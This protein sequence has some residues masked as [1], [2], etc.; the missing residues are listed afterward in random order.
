M[1]EQRRKWHAVQY[2]NGWRATSGALVDGRLWA[3]YPLCQAYIDGIE[4][5]WR[6]ATGESAQGPL[7]AMF[8][9]QGET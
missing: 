2:E 1:H 5:G 3:G 4:Q 8:A 6:D 7:A 9:D